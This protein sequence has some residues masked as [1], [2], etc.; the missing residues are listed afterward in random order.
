[1]NSFDSSFR[2]LVHWF[3]LKSLHLLYCH[4]ICFDKFLF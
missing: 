1:M 2:R 4:S 3:K